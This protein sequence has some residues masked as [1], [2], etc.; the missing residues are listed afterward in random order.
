MWRRPADWGVVT[1]GLTSCILDQY[2]HHGNTT[3]L[4]ITV[5]CIHVMR[6]MRVLYFF[7]VIKLYFVPYHIIP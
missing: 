4:Y 6:H 3:E 2:I 7:C 1:F 5:R